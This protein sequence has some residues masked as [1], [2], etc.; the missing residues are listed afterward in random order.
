MIG[1]DG[2]TIVAAWI[3]AEP[4][5]GEAVYVGA[6]GADGREQRPR[7]RLAPASKT[8][9]NLNLALD[10]ADPWVVFDAATSTRASELFLG[11]R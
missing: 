11:A 4:D 2:R 8:T 1:T 5:G 9:W 3:Q 10:G 6:W 7:T